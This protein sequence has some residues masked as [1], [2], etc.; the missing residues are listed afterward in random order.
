MNAGLRSVMK[1]GRWIKEED[2]SKTYS[3]YRLKFYEKEIE[4]EHNEAHNKK[5]TE[6]EARMV[7]K[8]LCRHFKLKW[9]KLYFNG[10]RQGGITNSSGWIEVCYNPSFGLI[11]HE[12]AHIIDRKKRGR[13]KHDKKFKRVITRVVNYCKKKNYW[14]EELTKRTEIKIKPEPTK[15]EL[16]AKKIEKRKADLLR[17]EKRLAY[18]TKLYNNK[19]KK[20]NRSI[21]TL[22]R[23]YESSRIQPLPLHK[24][25]L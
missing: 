19:I 12:I 14:E 22:K 15:E 9:V 21:A 16:R 24:G 1:M 20:A 10:R 4:E 25:H 13:S 3:P 18:F 23:N 6:Q 8:K 17:Y 2:G 7:F 11:C 5:L